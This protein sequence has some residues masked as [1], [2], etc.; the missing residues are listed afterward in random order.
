MATAIDFGSIAATN[1]QPDE[2]QTK[3]AGRKRSYEGTPVPEWVRESAE[4]G[5]GKSVPVPTEQAT[6]LIGMIRSAASIELDK[7]VKVQRVDHDGGQQST[8]QFIV[9][10]KRAYVKRS[11]KSAKK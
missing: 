8:I 4:Q 5:I 11:D 3:R 9:I 2:I 7:S 6:A 10:P 1:V